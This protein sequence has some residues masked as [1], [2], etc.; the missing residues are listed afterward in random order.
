[1]TESDPAMSVRFSFPLMTLRGWRGFWLATLLLPGLAVAE[2]SPDDLLWSEVETVFAAKCVRCHGGESQKA[3]LDL[4]SSDSILRG[5]ES[6]AVIDAEHPDESLLLEYITEGLMPPEDEPPLTATE[7]HLLQRWVQ[8]TAVHSAQQSEEQQLTQHDVLPILLLR[9][10][11]CHGRQDPQGG[12]D[13]RSKAS[14]LKGGKSGPAIVPGDPGNSRLLQ[15]V[16]AGDMPPRK[17]LVRAA[18]KPMARHEIDI[19]TRWIEA[20]APEKN[21]EPDVMTTEPD[22][23]VSDRERQFWAFQAPVAVEPPAVQHASQVRTP[24]DAFVLRKLEE[25]QLTLS[26]EADRRTLIR[27]A[28]F[29]LR[30]LPPTP[31]EIDVFLADES[32]QAWQLLIDRLLDSPRYGERWGQHWL[33]VAGYSDSEGVQHADPVRKHAWRYR[34]Y[35]IRAFNGDKPYDRFL[36]EQLA[37]DELADCE[38]AEE[39]TPELY[40]NL[41]A[42]GF[43]RLAPDG[44]FEPLTGFV[45]DRLE[46]IDDNLEVL[47]SA[48]MGLTIKCARCHSHKFDPIPQRDYYRLAAVF[49]GALDEHDWLKPGTRLLPYVTADETRKWEQ[50][51]SNADER[52]MIRALWDR[53]EPSP[54]YILQRGNYLSPGRLVGPGVPSVL[55]DGRTPL[56]IQPP[57]PGSTKTGRRLAFA[58]WLTRKD[59]PLTA[60]VLVNRVWK[61]HFGRGLVET[62]DNFG[63]AGARPSHPQLLDWLAVQLVADGWS[64][65]ALH[66]RMMTS[67]VYRQT[68]AVRPEHEARD[69]DNVLLS[70]MPLQRMEGEVLRDSLLFL[71]GQL[72]LTPF[73]PPDPVTARDDGL[74]TS[75]GVNGA[76]RWRRSIYLLRRRTQPVTLLQ[77]FD[78]G[79]MDPN[80]VERSESI[81]A[82]QA[83]HLKNNAWVFQVAGALSERVREQAGDDLSAQI[84]TAWQ[85]AAGREPSEDEWRVSREALTR[86]RRH[87]LEQSAGT[88]H[89]IMAE[90]HLWIREIEPQRV[91]EDDLVSVWSSQS[92]DKGRRWGLLEFDLSSLH[93]LQLTQAHLQ[94]GVINSD[95]IQQSASVIPVGI[96]QYNWSLFQQHK[97]AYRR[98]LQGLGR[99]LVTTADDAVT[100]GYESDAGA[101]ADDLRLL[102]TA[103]E[104]GGRLAIVL[105]ADETGDVWRRDWDDGVYRTTQ[106]HPPRLVVYDA[107]QDTQQASREALH[108]FCHGLMNSA[109]FLYID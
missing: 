39:I 90:H 25:Q 41:V 57:W 74:V 59:H 86:L 49:K 48:V 36:Q 28:S 95:P 99:V 3:E 83:L 77:N 27:R 7:I 98:P 20:G 29:D 10:A 84:R 54:A 12:L 44:T 50:A 89:E 22:L 47:S 82:P 76:A 16:H 104:A 52:P 75:A 70:R 65:K 88:R 94:L 85:L 13:V 79:R 71:A 67:A 6:G 43:L 24:I 30:G 38:Q 97:A 46:L 35:V 72:D 34:D 81:V 73:G 37:G 21:I 2:S 4:R 42:T 58:R 109:A 5:S 101:T 96:E 62:L 64:I 17:D 11:A 100:D 8:Q 45:P 1:M 102:E 31:E 51:G 15:R 9:C 40:D 53:G 87:R 14:L 103:V 108:D 60:R 93:G 18:V 23:L 33:D 63:T 92:T 106:H 69:P 66:R 61:H 19:V 26:P 32:P 91:F 56:E 107:R 105:Q 78:V 80:C 68:S 55:T